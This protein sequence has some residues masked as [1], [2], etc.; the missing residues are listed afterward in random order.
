MSQPRRWSCGTQWSIRTLMV[1]LDSNVATMWC[2]V[3]A[4]RHRIPFSACKSLFLNSV[5]LGRT[6]QHRT[7]PR[8]GP[9]P[10][11][12]I[13]VDGAVGRLRGQPSSDGAPIIPVIVHSPPRGSP[14][15]VP[16]PKTRQEHTG[17]ARVL[18]RTT[19]DNV[20]DGDEPACPPDQNHEAPSGGSH[21]NTAPSSSQHRG[22]RLGP[23]RL[24]FAPPV[25]TVQERFRAIRTRQ[26]RSRGQFLRPYWPY[27][28]VETGHRQRQRRLLARAA[29]ERRRLL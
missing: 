1:D 15:Q 29:L 24:V 20:V 7:A 25:P 22:V 26:C 23:P 3:C 12:V 19:K 18:Q 17:A 28:C 13:S 8:N 10:M 5:R 14:D 2:S 21:D 11:V 27:Q 4:T 16:E 9:A 6:R